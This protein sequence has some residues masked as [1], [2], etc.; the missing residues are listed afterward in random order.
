MKSIAKQLLIAVALIAVAAPA[1]AAELTKGSKSYQTRTE[2]PADTVASSA[3]PE[4][5]TQIAPAAGDTQTTETKT[6]KSLK[7]EIRLPRK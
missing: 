5:V 2:K 4:D 3:Q 7:E 1:F 6:E